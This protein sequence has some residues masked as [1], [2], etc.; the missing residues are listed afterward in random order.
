MIGRVKAAAVTVLPVFELRVCL[1]SLTGPDGIRVD[2][3]GRVR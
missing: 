2:W 3:G 1:T